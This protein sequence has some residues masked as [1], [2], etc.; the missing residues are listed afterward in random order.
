MPLKINKKITGWLKNRVMVE[1]EVSEK[2][3][4]SGPLG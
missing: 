1:V 2:K 4:G 3:K